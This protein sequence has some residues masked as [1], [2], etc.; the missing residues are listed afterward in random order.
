MEKDNF[1]EEEEAILKSITF[2]DFK[3]YMKIITDAFKKDKK[4]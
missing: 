1:T 2:E 3:R 4:E